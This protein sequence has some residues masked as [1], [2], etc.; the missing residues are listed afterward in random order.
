[1]EHVV[2]LTD[3][4]NIYAR[5]FEPSKP[6]TNVSIV[7]TNSLFSENKYSRNFL[8]N[9]AR[10]LCSLGYRVLFFDYRGMGESEGDSVSMSL[11]SISEDLNAAISYVQTECMQ[12]TVLIGFR[13]GAI[14]ALS[15]VKDSS[16]SLIVL[17]EPVRKGSELIRFRN[18]IPTEKRSFRQDNN[19]NYA[20]LNVNVGGWNINPGFCEEL[21]HWQLDEQKHMANSGKLY[22]V[23]FVPTVKDSYRNSIADQNRVDYVVSDK[24]WC[25]GSRKL[26]ITPAKLTDVRIQSIL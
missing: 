2:I 24:F 16:I 17:W 7:I 11:A 13:G 6:T 4:A 25:F 10:Q 14:P 8:I 23:Y 3:K 22:E 12:H 1:M 9:N 5:L 18:L 15:L 20:D 26:L 21:K 19:E